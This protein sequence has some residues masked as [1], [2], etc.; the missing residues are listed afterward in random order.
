MIKMYIELTVDLKH[1]NEDY[2]DLRLSDYNTVKE[3]IDIVWQAKAIPYPPK[4][5]YWVRVPN[6]QKVLSGNEQLASSGITTG[7]RL[8][9]L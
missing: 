7:D 5:G 8:E 3:L 4:E 9:I 6:K 1:Y 2:F